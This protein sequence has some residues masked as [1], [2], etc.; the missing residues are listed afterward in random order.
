M[1][2]IH[3]LRDMDIGIDIDMEMDIDDSSEDD[4][5]DI[6]VSSRNKDHVLT[7]V[8]VNTDLNKSIHELTQFY[9]ENAKKQLKPAQDRSEI[10]INAEPETTP[11]GTSTINPVQMLNR[12]L[13]YLMGVVDKVVP[14]DNPVA[15]VFLL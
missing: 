3:L 6:L 10:Q 11:Y 1:S 13:V 7:A 15:G 14:H 5:D 9:N 12:C 8:T 4:F 2:L